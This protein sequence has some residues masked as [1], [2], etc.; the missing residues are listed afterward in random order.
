M[1]SRALWF[2]SLLSAG[3]I[4]G[5]G[6]AVSGMT[7]PAK[8][9]NFLD[10]TG[11]WD[12]SLAFVMAGAVAVHFVLFRWVV[13]RPSPLFAE[14]FRLPDRQDIDRRLV[15]GSALFG[16]GWGL[17]GY[18]PGPAVTSLVAGHPRTFL[19]VASMLA[20]MVV[21]AAFDRVIARKK[22]E[23]EEALERPSADAPA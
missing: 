8:I 14:K 21:F 2:L 23:R 1:K 6:L 7:E 16:A 20:G 11:N 5:V 12:P 10:F 4:F 9:I 18:C 17:G 3:A 15:I 22:S 13:R 19:F